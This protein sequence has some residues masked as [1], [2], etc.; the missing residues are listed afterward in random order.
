MKDKL[1]QSRLV[2]L[3]S[4]RGIAA[5]GIVLW[6]FVA[7]FNATPFYFVFRPFYAGGLYL[8][9]F[10]FLLS[11]FILAYTYL[12]KKKKIS[13]SN[14]FIVRLIRLYP[15]HF[16]TLIVVLI[17]QLI[18][19]NFSNPSEF[20]YQYSNAKHFILNLFLING[21]GVEDGFSFNG[22][23]WAIS[24]LFFVNIL[25]FFVLTK[26]KNKKFF[27]VLLFLLPLI[28]LLFTTRDLLI[29]QEIPF[30][31][32]ELLR[33]ML[34]FFAGVLL[35]LFAKK[36]DQNI[37]LSHST[38]KNDL[39]FLLASLFLVIFMISGLRS[40]V[41]MDIVVACIVFPIVLLSSMR[42]GII[43]EILTIKPLV[44]LGKISF[45][46]YMT[47]YPVQILFRIIETV[48]K[49][50]FN[51]SS[52]SFFILVIAVTII[53]ADIAYRL[54]ELPTRKLAKRVQEK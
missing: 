11:G 50:Q 47:H 54:V 12:D 32:A 16:V 20:I 29:E 22:P 52:A 31:G 14:L 15:L 40:V 4:L 30:I 39:V 8:V 34:G 38:L 53:F 23:A 41:G 9:D 10:F 46:I 21:V 6:H 44:Y 17:Q 25:F 7:Q 48:F 1:T 13:F 2:E 49:F 45:A 35:F 27:F 3:D 28:I 24:T 19:T 51:Y 43:K 26:I 37:N 42:G 36:R 18:L 33:T 5:I